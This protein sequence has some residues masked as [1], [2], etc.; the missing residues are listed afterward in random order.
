MVRALQL[1]WGMV[2]DGIQLS[3]VGRSG[4]DRKGDGEMKTAS[5][6]FGMAFAITLAAG[7]AH[8]HERQTSESSG[9]MQTADEVSVLAFLND[10][11]NVTFETLDEE[12][13][14]RSDSARNIIKHRDG[15]DKTPGTADDNLF[16]TMEELDDV[17]M[18]G[19]TSLY[20][21]TV[22]AESYGYKPTRE[23]L[24]MLNFLND[25]ENT[26]F[27]RLDND[28]SLR[29]NAAANLIAYRNGPDGVFGTSDDN[30]FHSVAEVDGV[31]QVGPWTLD[32][33]KECA[34]TFGYV[35]QPISLIY[36]LSA[37]HP[38]IGVS[39]EDGVIWV[40]GRNA[41]FGARI[42]VRFDGHEIWFGKGPVSFNVSG[43]GRDVPAGYGGEGLGSVDGVQRFRITRDPVG[44]LTVEEALKE[45][46]KGLVIFL[47]EDRM[48]RQDW[49][50]QCPSFVTW[51][52][53]LAEGIMDGINGFG[54]PA[55]D[56][57]T[58]ISSTPTEYHFSG[59]GPFRLGT[60]V[61]VS[62]ETGKPIYFYVEID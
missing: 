43:V 53:A 15:N 48:K 6:L 44:T 16:D 42:Y 31:A 49:I 29:S 40:D 4:A 38:S 52:A 1:D 22:C 36:Q 54:D 10:Q 27:E 23:E 11:Q 12:C 41:P 8:P 13:G 59:R 28:C 18:V 7:C 26:T 30:P 21:L 35:W 19:E 14:L 33:L 51:E 9:A 39:Q 20:R 61:V 2:S 57:G 60:R 37:D 34:L 58:I 55:Y 24:A 45:A 17:S 62:K 25:Y 56:S 32:Q 3:R 5:K 47:K 50:E 46:R